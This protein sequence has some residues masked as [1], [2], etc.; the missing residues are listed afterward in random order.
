MCF[1]H[2]VLFRSWRKSIPAYTNTLSGAESLRKA[3]FRCSV[4]A[5]WRRR[6]NGGSPRGER[7]ARAVGFGVAQKICKPRLWQAHS[8]LRVAASEATIV[9]H[10]PGCSRR[11]FCGCGAAVRVFGAPIRSLWLAAN[12]FKFPRA[13]PAAGMVAVRR[14]HV[15]DAYAEAYSESP[16]EL[17]HCS[18]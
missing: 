17:C 13:Q 6:G 10:P 16:V 8:R 14:H 18:R 2:S 7:I 15:A 3:L 12:W 1:G 5:V 11:A 4:S 9:A